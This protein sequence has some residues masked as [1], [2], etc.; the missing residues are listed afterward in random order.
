MSYPTHSTKKA[1][2]I[3]ATSTNVCPICSGVDWCSFS[4]D[5]QQICCRRYTGHPGGEERIDK[6]NTRFWYFDFRDKKRNTDH[7]SKVAHV[8]N[9]SHHAKNTRAKHD[10]EPKAIPPDE[11]T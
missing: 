4:P 8:T 6:A 11:R 3:N 10:N 1:D 7:F 2:F 5:K 9:P